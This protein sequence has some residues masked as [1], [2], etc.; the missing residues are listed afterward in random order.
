MVGV[1]CW[2]KFLYSPSHTFQ[3][4]WREGGIFMQ[5]I[6]Q[7][8]VNFCGTKDILFGEENLF[9]NLL[10]LLKIT[11]SIFLYAKYSVF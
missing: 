4:K 10:C 11:P 5:R 1:T 6:L 8:M 3:M 2:T 9:S 7:L